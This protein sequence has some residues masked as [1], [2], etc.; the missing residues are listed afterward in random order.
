MRQYIAIGI[1]GLSMAIGL[2]ASGCHHQSAPMAMPSQNS[3][4]AAKPSAPSNPQSTEMQFLQNSSMPAAEREALVKQMQK[5]P[6]V[7]SH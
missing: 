4:V 1:V 7:G 3:S 5:Q 6:A 2:L